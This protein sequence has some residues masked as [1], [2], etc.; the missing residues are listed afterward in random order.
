MLPL[1]KIFDETPPVFEIVMLNCI[2]L[3]MERLRRLYHV[4]KRQ[5]KKGCL[6]L[7]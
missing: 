3:L 5:Y 2:L 6:F 7:F 4:N 1:N